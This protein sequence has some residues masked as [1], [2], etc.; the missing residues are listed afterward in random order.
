MVNISNNNLRVSSFIIPV[1]VDENRYMLLH[2]YSGA[3]ELVD[4]NIYK[5]LSGKVQLSFN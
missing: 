1:K 2:G 5:I 3:I 4:E